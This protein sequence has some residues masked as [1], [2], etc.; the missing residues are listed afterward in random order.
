MGA[1]LLA[2]A[3]GQPKL[4]GLINRHRE[5]ARSPKRP[6]KLDELGIGVISNQSLQPRHFQ[7]LNNVLSGE[8]GGSELDFNQRQ[9]SMNFSPGTG[10][11]RL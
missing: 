2:I 1:S 3:D 10:W 5:Q 8:P 11:T 4:D 6:S 7:P 9:V